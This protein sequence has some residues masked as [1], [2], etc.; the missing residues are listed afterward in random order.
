MKHAIPTLDQFSPRGLNVLASIIGEADV[1][2]LLSQRAT[3][4]ATVVLE[5]WTVVLDP[6]YAGLYDLALCSR[7][8]KHRALRKAGPKNP[9]RLD[10]WLT[11][12]AHRQLIPKTHADLLRA[13]PGIRRLPGRYRPGADSDDLRVVAKSVEWNPMPALP[14][15]PP[16]ARDGQPIHRL[17]GG[18]G[19]EFTTIPEL[20]ITGSGDDF[21][22]L[23]G[24]LAGDQFPLQ[25][26]PGLDELPYL[27]IPFRLCVG[28]SCPRMEQWEEQLADPDVKKII[29]S[30]M[31]CYRRKSEVRQERRTLGRHTRHGVRLDANRL[32]DAVIARRAGME[33]RL[34]RRTGSTIEP[35]FDPREHLVVITFDINDLRPGEP[36]WAWGDTRAMAHRFLASMVTTYQRLGVDCV[37]AAFADQ[38]VTLPDGRNVC[39]H[40][41]HTL[42]TVA[43]SFDDAFWNR[44]GFVLE[45]PLAFPGAPV[46]YHPLSL[47]DFIGTFDELAR[48][49]DHSYRANVWWARRWIPDEFSQL[50]S[51]D[52]L[53]RVADYI[54]TEM[55]DLPR[56]LLGTFDTL[57]SYLPSRLK[58]HGRPGRF[59]QRIEF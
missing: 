34:F 53:M 14:K 52:F 8:L 18:R 56:R 11:R 10:R 58:Q 9:E 41:F 3:H 1:R 30:L 59:L 31:D 25:V 4:P 15:D 49:S 39:L 51:T 17:F 13:Y 44:L 57:G 37:V 19:L 24:A 47:R 55:E 28:E 54:D 42:K 12:R 43:D 27:R 21:A 5:S 6:R 23:M 38:I 40:F 7:L 46:C 35:V 50:S 29:Q 20:D 45:R 2:V 16:T 48:E 22:W 33:P 36:E 26:I 32:V